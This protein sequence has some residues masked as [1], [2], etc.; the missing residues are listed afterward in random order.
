MCGGASQGH[1]AA[2]SPG[3]ESGHPSG[4]PVQHSTAPG[5]G[6]SSAVRWLCVLDQPWDLSELGLLVCKV[7]TIRPA[8][9]EGLVRLSVQLPALAKCPAEGMSPP[10]PCRHPLQPHGHHPLPQQGPQDAGVVKEG[11][12]AHP[13]TLPG[14]CS[15]HARQHPAPPKS[16]LGHISAWVRPNVLNCPHP[17]RGSPSCLQSGGSQAQPDGRMGCTV[18][19]RDPALSGLGA[20]ALPPQ[21]AAGCRGLL[22]ERS[23]ARPAF[24][25][26]DVMGCPE[27][28]TVTHT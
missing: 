3:G 10:S 27:A 26:T 4:L 8:A 22:P 28:A 9:S 13:G 14:G 12:G 15:L 2:G 6:P 17:L 24:D 23:P 19:R 11:A 20:P 7:G 18:P 21:S 25:E 1:E 16:F 5:P